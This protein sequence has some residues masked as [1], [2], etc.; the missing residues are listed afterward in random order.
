VGAKSR[1]LPPYPI[2]D[3]H[4]ARRDTARQ[5]GHGGQEDAAEGDS[6][7]DIIVFSPP[8]FSLVKGAALDA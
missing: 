1:Q 2:P 6:G 7:G 5:P 3:G 4:N 8:A